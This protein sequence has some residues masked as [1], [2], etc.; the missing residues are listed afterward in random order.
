VR[1]RVIDA[2]EDGKQLLRIKAAPPAP[3]ASGH[4]PAL[5]KIAALVC[6]RREVSVSAPATPVR[7]V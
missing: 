4:W 6:N 5:Q 2:P 7:L 3:R 1:D